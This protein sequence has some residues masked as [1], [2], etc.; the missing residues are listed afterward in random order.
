MKAGSLRSGQTFCTSPA[1]DEFG[2]AAAR[3]LG[4]A[5]S[6]ACALK[7]ARPAGVTDSQ[8]EKLTKP[9]EFAQKVTSTTQRAM[10]D[11]LAQ[12]L[13]VSRELITH[14]GVHRDMT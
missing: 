4:G 1:R 5:A 14:K 7:F 3:I 6:V 11:A 13:G 8:C 12:L 10:A 2:E 9:R